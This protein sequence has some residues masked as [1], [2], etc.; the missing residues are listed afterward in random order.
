[1][2]IVF[3]RLQFGAEA[4]ITDTF[5]GDAAP[6][7][8]GTLPRIR[9][10][11]ASAPIGQSRVYAGVG[12]DF[13][14]IV[15]QDAVGDPATDR[16]LYRFDL[17]PTVRTPIGN[18]PYLAVSAAAA[19]RFTYWSEQLDTTG[20]Q[21]AQSLTR[22]LA[23][24]RAEVAGPKF[25]RIFDTPG[26]GY[27]T[28]WKHVIQPTA[29]IERRTSF[30]HFAKVP[31]NDNVDTEVGGVTTITYGLSNSVLAKRPSPDGPG[32]AREVFLVQLQQTYYSDASA[33]AYDPQYELGAA[34]KLS[35]VAATA[36]S[37]PLPP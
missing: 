26:W 34:T 14:A 32:A 19:Y 27:A 24:F 13:T 8:Y 9:L 20:A 7:R 23:T 2:Q 1:M 5:N 16:G 33:A 31:K 17:N 11:L 4:G 36:F 30:T 28:R 29:T 10:D 21:V 6:V 18:L 35:P 12:S 3:A 15:R 22:Q 37:T 25:S